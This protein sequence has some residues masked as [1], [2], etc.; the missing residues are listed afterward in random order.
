VTEFVGAG[1]EQ[2]VDHL[3]S[4]FNEVVAGQ[5]PRM[6]A[7]LAASGVGKTRIVQ[8]FYRRLAA[9][10]QTPCYWPTTL[11]DDVDWKT[12]RKLL[13]VAKF[14]PEAKAEMPWLYWSVSC[15][16]RP[17][18][19]L[20]EAL[21]SGVNQFEVHTDYL[22]RRLGT[23]EATERGIDNTSAVMGMLGILGVAFPPL[24]IGISIAGA[25]GAVLK[26]RDLI[27]RHR[28]K[29]KYR[30]ESRDGTRVIDASTHGYHRRAEELV[31][32]VVKVSLRVPIIIAVDDAHWADEF[33]ILFLDQLLRQE[34][35]RVLIVVTAWPEDS[36]K[37][38]GEEGLS[39][40][41]TWVVN[42]QSES[43]GRRVEIRE[44][45][46]LDNSDLTELVSALYGGLATEGDPR[47]DDKVA[48]QLV[49]QLQ[50]PLAIRAFFD[51]KKV[52][53]QIH[54]GGLELQNL[55]DLPADLTQI[56]NAYWQELPEP[57]RSVL[58]IAATYGEHFARA[59]VIAAAERLDQP[60]A[61]RQLSRS[62]DPYGMIRD[63]NESLEEF[64]DFLHHRPALAQ[65]HE[66]FT[67][68]E[69]SVI[70]D[71]VATY[72]AE[73]SPSGTPDPLATTVWATV[74]ALAQ[75]DVRGL[76]DREL[77][78]TSAWLL[79]GASASV[80]AY[81]DALH[82]GNLSLEWGSMPPGNLELLQKLRILANW[83]GELG[84]MGEAIAGT[85]DV[86]QR[87]LLSLEPGDLDILETKNQL[88]HWTGESGDALAAAN[89]Y[90]SLL[91]ELKSEHET[92]DEEELSTRGHLAHWIGES[93][94]VSGALAAYRSLLDDQTRLLGGD[95][96]ETL[97]TRNH[98]AHWIGESGDV[99]GA[100]VAYRSLL[101]DQTRLLGGDRL[102]TLRTRNNLVH[103]IG[104]SGDVG[105]AVAACEDLLA[106][107]MRILGPDQ[108]D[109]LRTRNHLAHWIRKSGDEK[110]A[111]EQFESLLNDQIRVLG[112]NHPD[113]LNT[114]RSIIKN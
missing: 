28:L 103:W 32:D 37:S 55:T 2:F 93:G 12:G 60:D 82:Y 65:S 100:L 47:L 1:R 26:D 62:R 56:M 94:D 63:L 10:Q 80:S 70:Y 101:D 97:W 15:W 113:T 3:I 36:D 21:F 30:E 4:S 112:T 11:T 91:D 84:R 6:V 87:Q 114:K 108:P 79:A 54:D 41:A 89:L 53:K 9:A 35:A 67:E 27:E 66:D 46:M 16:R 50:G 49:E 20:H 110:A 73:L 39:P 64:T 77:A 92:G 58:A 109:T 96:V 34:R 8:E 69:L 99:S 72:A 85:K 51:L 38:G 83:N 52:K 98:L 81:A 68:R 25:T 33:T 104:E 40:F 88:A 105:A 22:L 7:L 75:N 111:G 14:Q 59:P 19:N 48:A 24:A 29:K 43:E 90:R 44:V 61:V 106:D 107:E 102:E 76:V 86:L 17:D 45:E 57:V 95:D 23:R 74:V 18:G 78:S 13:A 42:V 71:T 5:G 31:A